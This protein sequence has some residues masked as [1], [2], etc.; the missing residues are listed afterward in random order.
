MVTANPLSPQI[1]HCEYYKHTPVIK[2]DKW[3]LP[4]TRSNDDIHSLVDD[5]PAYKLGPHFF[6]YGFVAPLPSL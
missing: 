5:A 3:K 1:Q 2:D 6:P 4:D